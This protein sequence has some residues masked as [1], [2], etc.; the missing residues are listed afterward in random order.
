MSTKQT[1]HFR[2][3]NSQTQEI[4]Q[5]SRRVG[6]GG[7][8]SGIVGS[9]CMVR[10]GVEGRGPRFKKVNLLIRWFGQNHSSGSARLCCRFFSPMPGLFVRL[11]VFCSLCTNLLKP[12]L[13]QKFPFLSLSF[14]FRLVIPVASGLF[15]RVHDCLLLFFPVFMFCYRFL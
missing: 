12:T 2:R 8:Q 4:R 14:I 3:K 6:T 9:R 5:G 15:S 11:S 7:N 13:Q 10:R 1:S